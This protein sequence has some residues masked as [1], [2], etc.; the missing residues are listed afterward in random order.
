MPEKQLRRGFTLIELAVVIIL[1]LALLLLPGLMR[2]RWNGAGLDVSMNNVR[3]ILAATAHYRLDNAGRVPMRGVPYSNGIITG[4]WD[5][6]NAFGKNCSSWWIGQAFDE[7]AYSRPLNSY[8]T[9]HERIPRP[10][11]Y[12]NTGS[13]STWN[14]RPGTPTALQRQSFQLPVCKSPGDLATR[15]RNWPNPTPGI[16]AY[17]DV[18]TSYT[19]NFVWWGQP[20]WPSNFTQQFNAGTERIRTLQPNDTE[21]PYAWIHDQVAEV[22]ASIHSPGFQIKGEFSGINKSV[23]GFLTGD[24]DYLTVTPGAGS[25]VGY[26]FL[27]RP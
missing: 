4:G 27:L 3:Q 19:L 7:S 20:G 22:V 6:W 8:L 12:L 17:D 11:G 5:T 18:G 13:G 14:F 1:L 10:S 15:Q 2:Q 23:M 21:R 16:S 26:T 25:G 24:V 9:P